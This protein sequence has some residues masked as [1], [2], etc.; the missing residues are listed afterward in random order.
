MVFQRLFKKKLIT[1]STLSFYY[2][3]VRG[4]RTKLKTILTSATVNKNYDVILLTETWLNDN[5]DSAELGLKGYQVYR[6]D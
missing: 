1:S 5:F 4:L 6:T 3:N 2:Q